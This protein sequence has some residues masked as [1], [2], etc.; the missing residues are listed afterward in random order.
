MSL[1]D[2]F[3]GKPDHPMSSIK[4]VRQFIAELPKDNDLK[5]LEEVTSWL[6]SIKD[7]PGFYLDTRVGIF[8]LID[9]TGQ[10]IQAEL[11]K[12]YLAEPH[13][14]DFQGMSLWKVIRGYL[15]AL[16]AAYTLCLNEYRG[17]ESHSVELREI[18]PVVCVRLLRAAAEWMKL[19]LM[20]YIDVDAIVWEHLY[21]AYRL[22]EENGWS[23]TMVF[24]YPKVAVHTNPQRELVRGLMLYESSPSTL[25]PDQIEV[26]FRI[27]G[28][29]VSFFD[30]NT[31]PDADSGYFIDLSTFAPPAIVREGITAT[32][33]RRFF[34]AAKALPKVTEIIQQNESGLIEQERRFGSEF[35]PEGKLTVLKHLQMYWEKDHPRRRQERR[36]IQADIEVVHGFRTISKL[37][38]RVDLGQATANLPEKDAAKLKQQQAQMNVVEE[39][40]AAYT[41]ETWSVQNVSLT[42]IGGMIPRGVGGWVKIG[43]LCGIKAQNSPVWW[44]GMIRRLHTDAHGVAQVGLEILAKKPLSLWLRV[45]GKG[46]EKVSNWETS[47]GSFQYDYLPAILLPDAHNSFV[48]ATLLIE[49]GNYVIDAVFEIMLGEKS[50]EIKLTA[51]VDEGEDYER[52]AFQW[53]NPASLNFVDG[54]K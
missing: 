18:M 10:P 53:I 16:S 38:T 5:A 34:G 46:V 37:V 3:S 15:G 19:E 42:G 36:D 29:L 54:K 50:R 30:F 41:S 25:A 35:T 12:T 11:L 24:A 21:G 49:T 44:V 4:E 8:M 31:E 22:A 20:R 9:E 28:R 26:C 33:S 40:E 47:S 13:L 1:F 51:L 23:E 32:P 27:A 7:T 2:R 17:Q 43:D 39:G 48:H 45:L 6:T 14:Q 52:V